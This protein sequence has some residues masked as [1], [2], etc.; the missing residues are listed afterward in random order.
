M[1]QHILIVGAGFGGVWSALAAAD[2]A[3]PVA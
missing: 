2:P 1:K 3:F